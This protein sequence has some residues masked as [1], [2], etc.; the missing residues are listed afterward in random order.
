MVIVAAGGGSFQPK[1]PPIPGIEA[2]EHNSVHYA[3]RRVEDFRDKNVVIVGGGDLAL[4]WTLK[5]LSSPSRK[6]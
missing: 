6:A 5:F 4:D 3:V 1:K 2:Y